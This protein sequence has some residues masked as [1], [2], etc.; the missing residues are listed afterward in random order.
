[1]TSALQVL[2]LTV[3]SFLFVHELDAIRKREWRFFFARVPVSDESAYR[4]FTALHAPLFVAILWYVGSPALQVGVDAFAILHGFVHLGLRNHP[5]VAFDSR[6]S[7][8]WIFGGALL[9][10]V[11]LVFVL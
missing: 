8:F 1:V 9:G 6:F 5:K 2:F 10:A 11:H 3:L 7:R 4:I